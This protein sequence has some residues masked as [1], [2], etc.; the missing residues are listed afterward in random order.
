MIVEIEPLSN[1][2]LNDVL[3]NA[4][5]QELRQIKIHAASVYRL[6]WP[7]GYYFEKLILAHA[8]E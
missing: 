8:Q 7:V 5:A 4:T 6:V 2:N 3:D 1:E